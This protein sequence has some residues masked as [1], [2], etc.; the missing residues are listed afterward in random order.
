MSPSSFGTREGRHPAQR[1][2]KQRRLRASHP[3][4][5]L[6]GPHS[7]S[8]SWGPPHGL[9][10]SGGCADRKLQVPWRA[11]S[12]PTPSWPGYPAPVLGLPDSVGTSG[13]KSFPALRGASLPLPH[14]PM[15]SWG[16]GLLVNKPAPCRPLPSTRLR[17]LR[18]QFLW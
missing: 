7:A 13:Q 6:P 9:Q 16:F 3:S 5:A 18:L 17:Q 11:D 8:L 1:T 15:I 14:S 2:G 12:Y 10:A 4:Q